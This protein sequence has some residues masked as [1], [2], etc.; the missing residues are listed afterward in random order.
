MKNVLR[1]I[2]AVSVVALLLLCTVTGSLISAGA[3]TE[4]IVVLYTNDVHCGTDNYAVFAAYRAQLISEGYNVVTIDAGD[5]LQG[6]MIGALTEGQAI[7]DIMNSVGYDYAVP[8]NHEQRLGREERYR[9][10]LTACGVH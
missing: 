3:E 4:E 5:A 8:G 7:V 2:L 1:K 10:I 6:E 9:K